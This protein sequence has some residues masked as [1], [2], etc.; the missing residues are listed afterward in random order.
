MIEPN[1]GINWQAFAVLA[2]LQ[3]RDGLECSWNGERY[4][5]RVMSAPWYNCRERGVV[6]YLVHLKSR[7]QAN[8]A[9]FEHRVGDHL[10]SA[11]WESEATLNPPSLDDF[12]DKFDG[13]SWTKEWKHGRVSDAAD[14]VYSSLEKFWKDCDKSVA[15]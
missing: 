7:R 9:L 3:S 2:N 6:F 8:I 12:A 10:C 1:F 13:S 4:T 11:L 14:W 5:A 15:A